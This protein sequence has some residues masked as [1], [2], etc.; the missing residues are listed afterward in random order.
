MPGVKGFLIRTKVTSVKRTLLLSFFF[1][2]VAV[3]ATAQPLERPAAGQPTPTQPSRKLVETVRLYDDM[4]YEIV[5]S[6][7][8]A[9]PSNVDTQLAR[10]T[11]NM[12]AIMQS[13]ASISG[14]MAGFAIAVIVFL[15]GSR[16]TRDLRTNVQSLIEQVIAT[17]FAAFFSVFLASLLFASGAGQPPEGPNRS[18]VVLMG[19]YFPFATSMFLFFQG[20][21]L[22]V[23]ERRLN[24]TLRL[25]SFIQ[26]VALIT[27]VILYSVMV[28]EASN[29]R[30]EI[31]SR[32]WIFVLIALIPSVLG[33]II[34]R[35]CFQSMPAKVYQKGF[36][37]FLAT[38]M[39]LCL[40]SY[41]VMSFWFEEMQP[42]F[43]VPYRVGMV[44]LIALAILGA[45]SI[46]YTP[47]GAI[48]DK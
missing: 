28:D 26:Y 20:F 21:T 17:F 27:I 25:F 2:T 30:T 22:F 4:T 41:V 46:I 42:G 36:R 5:R 31:D 11:H 23:V 39:I 48:R 10:D 24:Y 6:E 19:A 3:S 7:T 40:A 18:F 1:V 29:P 44:F 16:R 8:P 15:I 32:V 37:R 12:A 33:F 34:R 9:T 14:A 38:C 45:G 13:Y 47:E 43:I 35:R